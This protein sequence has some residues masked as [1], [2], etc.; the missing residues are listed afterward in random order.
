MY[1]KCFFYLLCK[2]STSMFI[3]TSQVLT[4]K[5]A[6]C[7]EVFVQGLEVMV[8]STF[9]VSDWFLGSSRFVQD[10]ID[11]G[12]RKFGIDGSWGR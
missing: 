7:I 5:K 12:S 2:Y 6:I 4:M 9:F 3:L 10:L 8:L 11:Q 1:V